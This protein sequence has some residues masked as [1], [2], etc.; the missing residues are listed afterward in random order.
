MPKAPDVFILIGIHIF[1]FSLPFIWISWYQRE[2][3]SFLY[4]F[5]AFSCQSRSNQMLQMVWLMYRQKIYKRKKKK[6]N[7]ESRSMEKPC[8]KSQ[9][10]DLLG[11]MSFNKHFD[12][13][14]WSL[15]GFYV[16]G[17]TFSRFYVPFSLH[18]KIIK[19]RR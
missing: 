9:L 3:F 8:K 18:Y 2:T 16:L 17:N 5:L 4:F 7:D 12:Y 1:L 19:K 11:L 10:I 14:I 6:K 15:L 13:I